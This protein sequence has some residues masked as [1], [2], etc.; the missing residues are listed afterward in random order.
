MESKWT[1][2]IES[3]F[4]ES[5]KFDKNRI[6]NL[7]E[8]KYSNKTSKEGYYIMGVDVGRFGLRYSSSKTL[9]I[10]GKSKVA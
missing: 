3:A 10:A 2:D 8:Y 5:S 1:G 9:L 4:F 7:P 6:I